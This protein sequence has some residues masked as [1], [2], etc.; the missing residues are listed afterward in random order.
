MDT[1]YDINIENIL[2]IYINIQT[3]IFAQFAED[4]KKHSKAVHF[5]R[6]ECNKYDL[7]PTPCF[8]TDW[9]N[10]FAINNL[11][12]AFQCYGWGCKRVNN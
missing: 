10:W 6:E 3:L 7:T 4:S 9:S 8:Y 1:N 2:Y 12:L 5:A 11:K